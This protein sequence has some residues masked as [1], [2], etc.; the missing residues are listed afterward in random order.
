MHILRPRKGIALAATVV[1]LLAC[2]AP[3][4]AQVGTDVLARQS[5]R[6]YWYVFIAY[7]LAWVLLM[8]WVLSIGR[9][10]RRLEDAGTP[11]DRSA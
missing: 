3:A 8:G 5:L 6:P 9:R 10:I 2:A 4:V 1:A 7:S 11:E